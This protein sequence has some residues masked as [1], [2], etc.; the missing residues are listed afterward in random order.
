MPS[1]VS[2]IMIAI[3]GICL[4]IGLSY[5]LTVRSVRLH[6][7][8]LLFSLLCMIAGVYF[9]LTLYGYKSVVIETLVLAT[10][11]E[12]SLS[13]V[14]SLIILWF[15]A[16]YSNYKPGKFLVG[17]T[18]F[19]GGLAVISV[20]LP[21]SVT[22]QRIDAVVTQK[23][24]WNETINVLT[25]TV[26]PW[27]Y[28]S[29]AAYAAII[30]FGVAAFHQ[31]YMVKNRKNANYLLVPLTFAIFSFFNDI[32]LSKGL[33][34]SFYLMPYVYG[35]IILF[36]G[37]NL[38]TSRL[39]AMANYHTLF[40]AVNDVVTVHDSFSGRLLDANRAAMRIK[41]RAR[42]RKSTRLNSSHAELSRMPSSA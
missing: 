16:D 25:G 30:G 34:N 28:A 15:L 6:R 19:T 41:N 42:D 35:V 32:L 3:A 17:L 31:L 22:W 14:M 39:R 18:V 40:D 37:N 1:P 33:T 27:G 24:P 13:L 23:T 7:Q 21:F 2:I 10:R 36:I 26:S 8:P 4:Y 11:W 38:E 12:E 9:I 29:F 20:F 5:L